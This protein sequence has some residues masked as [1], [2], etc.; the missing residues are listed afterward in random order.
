[1]EKLCRYHGFL[2]LCLL[3][4][5]FVCYTE[6]PLHGNDE[7]GRVLRIQERN[8]R[9]GLIEFEF[10][11]EAHVDTDTSPTKGMKRTLLHRR[12]GWKGHGH[13]MRPCPDNDTYCGHW[14]GRFWAPLG[15]DYDD[16]RPSEARY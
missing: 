11:M 14:N 7:R 16:V 10:D 13:A 15:C 8:I 9:N 1:M 5:L 6:L 12:C 3:C 4:F 2:Y